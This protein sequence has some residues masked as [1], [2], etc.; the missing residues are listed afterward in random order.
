MLVKTALRSPALPHL[1]S[2]E[3][4]TRKYRSLQ[5]LRGFAAWMVVYHHFMQMFFDLKWGHLLGVFFSRY[6]SFGVDIFFVLSGF[7]MFSAVAKGTVKASSFA[8]GRVF[9]IMPAYWFHTFVT[10]I[11]ITLFPAGF[12]FTAY[13][14]SSLVGSLLL[15]PTANPS[16]IGVY[17]LLTVGWTLSFE[18]FFY[19]SLA[20]CL[21]LNQ[22]R[23]MLLCFLL[24]FVL[25]IVYPSNNAMSRVLSSSLL[26]EFLI[27]V[28]VAFL[29]SRP[30]IAAWSRRFCR[31]LSALLL[32][33]GL[34]AMAVISW[35]VAYKFLAAGLLVAAAVA[36]EPL[37]NPESN[38]V[39]A[40][41]RLGDES[42]ST[43]LVH[44]IV[45]GI[46]LQFFGKEPAG[47]QLLMAVALTSVLV[48]AVSR[49]SH[50]H[51][52]NN[53]WTTRLREAALA[54]FRSV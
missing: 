25:P 19:M 15:F 17:P 26:Y 18:M 38:R 34:A 39:K 48:L 54:R 22:R 43:Y 31:P 7:V 52:E 20:F 42:Y 44:V 6:G 28:A 47:M 41:V 13:S 12:G 27:G 16:G 53:A 9:R 24:I 35:G 36:I 30:P 8:I 45:L 4:L 46:A 11:C 2:E 5:I 49:W 33:T 21:V 3:P 23:A 32:V 10:L 29:A 50:A 1:S 37:I 40:L 51:V 14:L